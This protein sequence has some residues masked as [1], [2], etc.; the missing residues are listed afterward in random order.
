V[1]LVLPAIAM[2]DAVVAVP[3]QAHPLAA[4]DLYQVFDT[5]D[6]PGGVVKVV[7]GERDLLARTPAAHDDVAGMWYLETAAGAKMVEVAPAG[8]LKQTWTENGA[9]R[10]WFGPMGQGREFLHRAAQVKNI[11]DP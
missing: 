8:N 11:W 4:T 1:S 2:G 6:L 3:S 9:A 10:N 7:T 5:S